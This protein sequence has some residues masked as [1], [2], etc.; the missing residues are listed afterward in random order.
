V[1]KYKDFREEGFCALIGLIL[2]LFKVL[3]YKGLRVLIAKTLIFKGFGDLGIASSLRF[4][5]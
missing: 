2:A 5:Q 1:L 3:F 4:S